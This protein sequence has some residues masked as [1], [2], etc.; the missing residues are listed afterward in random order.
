MKND[1]KSDQRDFSDD[2]SRHSGFRFKFYFLLIF[3]LVVIV[4]SAS[5][6]NAPYA[7]T[8][9]AWMVTGTNAVLN[10]MATPNGLPTVAWFEWGTNANY[11]N[12]TP[13][14][15]AGDGGSVVWVTNQIAELLPRLIYHFRIVASNS[16]GIA[17]GTD[18]IFGFGE[19]VWP[20]GN[21]GRYT[22]PKDLTN[23]AAIAAVGYCSV[24][25]RDDGT[26][27]A[28]GDNYFGQTNVPAGLSSVVALGGECWH[29]L[30]LKSDGTV[31]A[32]GHDWE[33]QTDV[34][35]GLDNVV[36]V[37]GGSSYSLALK[38]DG[39]I[40]AWGEEYYLSSVPAG[41]SNIVAIAAGNYHS[42][43]LRDDGTIVAW[44][45]GRDGEI[46][47][48]A[49]LT[50]VVEVAAGGYDSL[51]LKGDGTVVEWGDN[52]YDQTN[53]PTQV[54]NIVAAAVG[55]AHSLALRN[56]GRLMGWGDSSNG[57]AQPPAGLTDVVAFAA[58]AV[59][60]LA[61]AAD[62]P[63]SACP[64]ACSGRPNMDLTLRLLG[65][66]LNNEF[67][68]IRISSLPESG[69]L[70]QSD[71]GIRGALIATNGTWVEDSAGYVIFAPATNSYGTPYTTFQFVANDG[72][73]DSLPATVTIS[74]VAP[75][76]L[77][78]NYSITQSPTPSFQ[79]SF[80][81]F[82][83]QTYSAWAS[84]NLLDWQKLGTASEITPGTYLFA[85]P[86][87]NFPMR[88]YQLRWP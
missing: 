21:Y 19:R 55:G 15:A 32:W 58:G 84:T 37:A 44:G 8:A 22:M 28:W 36:A 46:D 10:G 16:L 63:P 57:Q 17:C 45:D 85:D 50:N 2:E 62:S 31:V 26:V 75:T 79:V 48:P 12:Q 47:V 40:V 9:P 82:S 35:G 38:R 1:R 4:K 39:T 72:L 41:L 69:A 24:A 54:T 23:V 53:V 7:F 65:T 18:R 49:S 78:S 60:S 86:V 64:Q 30:A 71:S 20:W 5:A 73:V 67:L 76:I 34:P 52:T 61:L 13:V 43:A 68:S 59:Q 25:L 14:I 80:G 3:F 51:V 88:F 42:L 83:N 56:D 66:D 87:T 81:A 77:I 33:G 74:I 6:V 29:N 70:Y 27:E 11:G